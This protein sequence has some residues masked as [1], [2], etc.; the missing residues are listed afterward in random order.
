MHRNVR[1]MSL[2]IGGAGLLWLLAIA[3]GQADTAAGSTCEPAQPNRT[4]VHT[5]TRVVPTVMPGG[6]MRLDVDLT[7][8]GAPQ[9]LSFRLLSFV[10]S[11]QLAD[12][13]ISH[14][15]HLDCGETRHLQLELAPDRIGTLNLFFRQLPT[16]PP[17][18]RSGEPLTQAELLRLARTFTPLET[19]VLGPTQPFD[20][21]TEQGIDHRYHRAGIRQGYLFLDDPEGPVYRHVTSA[22]SVDFG[23]FFS[24]V[25]DDRSGVYTLTCMVNDEQIP[26][27]AGRVAWSGPVGEGEGV[28]IRGRAPLRDVGWHHLSCVVLN[29]LF[30]TPEEVSDYPHTIASMFVMRSGPSR[31]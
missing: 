22:S 12:D 13:D 11:T 6:R 3:P 8:R 15:L 9:P 29:S 10:G 16:I 26:A 4:T 1:R 25:S 23:L 31:P 14:T 30:A 21:G 24:E 17:A 28:V 27:F 5:F 19:R 18:I 20:G 2:F 7:L